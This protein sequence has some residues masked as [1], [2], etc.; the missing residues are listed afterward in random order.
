MNDIKV[1]QSGLTL[2][3]PL[4]VL[5]GKE[6]GDTEGMPFAN[7]ALYAVMPDRNQPFTQLELHYDGGMKNIFDLG[8]IQFVEGL[9]EFSVKS[10]V[11][12]YKEN[13]QKRIADVLPQFLTDIAVSVQKDIL[14]K[15]NKAELLT[16]K[17]HEVYTDWIKVH[18]NPLNCLEMPDDVPETQN[19]I[20][21][22]NL[23]GSTAYLLAETVLKQ[24]F[25]NESI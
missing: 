3:A 11:E 23:I 4:R 7:C 17:E 21:G 15:L 14:Y 10:L 24:S 12:A 19:Y 8:D 13:N 18:A 20:D 22:S 9:V 2:A 25:F 1:A 6:I 5:L 16:D